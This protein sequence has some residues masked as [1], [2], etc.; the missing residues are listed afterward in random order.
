M[1]GTCGHPT[2]SSAISRSSSCWRLAYPPESTRDLGIVMLT[3]LWLYHSWAYIILC[4][5]NGWKSLN[6]R[7]TKRGLKEEKYQNGRE[8][9][10][11]DLKWVEEKKPSKIQKG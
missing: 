7:P 8:E 9:G 11:A 2:K 3:L 6:H 10:R 4:E 1:A 5:S